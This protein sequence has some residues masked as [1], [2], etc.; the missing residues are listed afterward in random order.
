MEN[1]VCSYR[2]TTLCVLI[3]RAPDVRLVYNK[4]LKACLNVT[5]HTHNSIEVRTAN[6]YHGSCRKCTQ[7]VCEYD[8]R[9][10]KTGKEC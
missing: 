10:R 3:L 8:H 6:Q 7:C 4:L 9:A 2:E 1:G 5:T